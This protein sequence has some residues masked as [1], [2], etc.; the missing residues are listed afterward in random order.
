MA[1]TN[2]ASLRPASSPP[3]TI[4]ALVLG[5]GCAGPALAQTAAPIVYKSA[6]PGS[7]SNVRLEHRSDSLSLNVAPHAPIPT[8]ATSA[9]F[10]PAPM[11]SAPL[12]DAMS[13]RTAAAVPKPHAEQLATP[14]AGPPYQVDGRWYVPAHEPNYDEIGIASWYGPTFHG[15]ASASG[16]VFNQ[17]DL[18]AAHPTLPIPSLVKVTNLE[19]GRAV[20]VRLNDRG[21]FVD[22][23]II[24][25]SKAAAAALDM[26]AKGT[27]RVRVQYVGPAPAEGGG[28]VSAAP[29][30]QLVS[31]V[32]APMPPGRATAALAAPAPSTPQAQPIITGGRFFVQAGSFADLANA[33]KLRARLAPYGQV[34]VEAVTVNGSEFYRVMVGPWP[35]RPRADAAR[36]ILASV[37]LDG[38][39]VSRAR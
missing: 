34:S 15:K 14:F 28:S 9:S 25:L 36:E 24:D 2:A 38:L 21:P 6:V 32:P 20:V 33:H 16:E 19:N 39:V 7:I 3:A 27:A 31:L 17:D 37:G 26:Q 5:F 29:A 22:D 18:T 35:D 11:A 10:G 30:P 8:F 13:L 4:L 23:R 12:P 1:R